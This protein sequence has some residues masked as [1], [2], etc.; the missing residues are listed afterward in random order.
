MGERLSDLHQQG[1]PRLQPR[2]GGRVHAGVGMRLS[3]LLGGVVAL[4]VVAAL[5]FVGVAVTEINYANNHPHAFGPA[6][7]IA[8]AAGAGALLA[9]SVAG[10][11]VALTRANDASS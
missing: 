9:T 10:L 8:W 3:S 2:P 7:V 6:H 1:D 5:I 11:A 4:A